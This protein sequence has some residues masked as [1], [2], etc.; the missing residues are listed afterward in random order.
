MRSVGRIC[1][2]AEVPVIYLRTYGQIAYLRQWA[3]EHTVMQSK[4]REVCEDLRI[5]RPFPTLLALVN[6]YDFA[7]MDNIEHGHIPWA[8]I[9][10]KCLQNWKESHE[11]QSPKTMEEK[12]QFKETIKAMS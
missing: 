8:V 12:N 3:G 1:E 4:V 6:S 5:H 10:I 11:G 9:L 7:N 2:S